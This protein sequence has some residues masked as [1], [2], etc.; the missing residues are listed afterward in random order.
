M[1][2]I[3]ALKRPINTFTHKQVEEAIC[4]IYKLLDSKRFSYDLKILTD[5]LRDLQERQEFE[6]ASIHK[7]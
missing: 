3:Q 5:R 1:H 4:L 7:K 2:I 6:N